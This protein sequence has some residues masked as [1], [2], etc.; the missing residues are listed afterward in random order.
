MRKIK[1]QVDHPPPPRKAA[2]SSVARDS[3][4]TAKG[5]LLFLVS[6]PMIENKP[7][8]P[9]LP[10]AVRCPYSRVHVPVALCAIILGL[11]KRGDRA[12]PNV[13]QQVFIRHVRTSRLRTFSCAAAGTGEATIRK[14]INP[15][16]L[17]DVKRTWVRLVTPARMMACSMGSLSF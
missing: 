5:V 14:S 12:T 7:F 3:M 17:P 6:F 15:K 16:I 13:G 8:Q 2:K 4:L 1:E 9:A 11:T 10:A